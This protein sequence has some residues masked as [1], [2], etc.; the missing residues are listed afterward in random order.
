MVL[1][2]GCSGSGSSLGPPAH[3]RHS[4]VVTHVRDGDTVTLRT[5]GKT[6]LIG[7]DTPEVFGHVECFGRAASAFTKR[8]LRVG[9]KVE[10][11]LGPET[12]DRYGR[13]LAY[14]WL[15]DGRMFNEMLAER[16]YAT[17]LTIPPDDEYARRFLAAARRAREASR[18]LWSP[19]TCNGV[20]PPNRGSGR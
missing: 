16:G 4:A 20:N 8:V 7:I 18:G 19:N 2:A 13:S 6:R 9:T 1:L 11:R 15:D 10:Y 5:N 3:G 17:P 12:H 14:I